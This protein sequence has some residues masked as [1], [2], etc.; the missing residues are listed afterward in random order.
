[1]KAMRGESRHPPCPLGARGDS[2]FALSNA[3]QRL[4][5]TIVPYVGSAVVEAFD[6]TKVMPVQAGTA[7]FTLAGGN[8]ATFAFTGR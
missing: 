6:T 3:E 7:T 5:G 1:M 4:H 8:H 2:R